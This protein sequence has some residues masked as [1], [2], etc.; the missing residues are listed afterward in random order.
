M[1]FAGDNVRIREIQI[2]W[3]FDSTLITNENTGRLAQNMN[4]PLFVSLTEWKSDIYRWK[5]MGISQ[6][7]PFGIQY[8]FYFTFFSRLSDAGCV[9]N[10]KKISTRLQTK[11][12]KKEKSN[13]TCNHKSP[14]EKLF[15]MRDR[16]SDEFIKRFH[17][18]ISNS[19]GT[20]RSTAD[21]HDCLVRKW[22]IWSLIN[23]S[24]AFQW[25]QQQNIHN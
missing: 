8:N 25:L 5:R 17:Y 20:G 14:N 1:C 13:S 2:N 19:I 24:M 22:W 23:S 16:P 9:L 15:S 3:Y 4:G 11:N 18:F 12:K 6:T 21:A 7:F 10:T